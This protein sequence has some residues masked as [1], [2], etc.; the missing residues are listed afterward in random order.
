MAP[1]IEQMAIARLIERGILRQH[2]GRILWVFE[3]RRYPLIDGKELQEVK[4]RIADLLLSDE[5]PD[6]RD[7]VIIALAQACGLLASRVLGKRVAQRAKAH[8]PNRE[9]RPHRPGDDGYDAGTE[10]RADASPALR[11]TRT[12]HPQARAMS[13]KSAATRLAPPDQGRHRHSGTAIN[14]AAF[15]GLT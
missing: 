4:K 7:I 2:E 12:R 9:A 1:S 13:Q 10:R 8:R 11:L 3:T 14:S 5:I 6:P 15:D